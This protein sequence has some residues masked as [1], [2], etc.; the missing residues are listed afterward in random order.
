MINFLFS[1]ILLSPV[2]LE[3]VQTNKQKMAVAFPW[4]FEKGNRTARTLAV[5]TAEEIARTADYASVPNDVA[6]AAWTR[7]KLPMPR[8][9]TMP[10][11]ATLSKFARELHASKVLFGSVAWHTRSIWVNAGPKTIS[12]ATVTACVY[13]AASNKIVYQKNRVKGRSDEKSNG[14]K[15]AAAILITPLVTAVS[16]GPATP[17]EQR[18]VQIGMGNAFNDWVNPVTRAK[19]R[20]GN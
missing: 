16:G 14:Y 7:L 5:T 11:M 17:Q 4:T 19:S 6:A 15:I 9:G 3:P 12:T 1:S 8:Y 13:D 18:A 10:S 20:S 2:T